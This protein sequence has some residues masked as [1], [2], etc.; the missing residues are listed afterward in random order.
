MQPRLINTFLG[1]ISMVVVL[2]HVEAAAADGPGLHGRVLGLDDEG[3]FVGVVAGATI[4]FKGQGGAVAAQTTS[5]AN[6][7]YRV[8]LPAG[9]YTYKIEA[10]GYR[11]EDEGRG[12]EIH[13]SEGY[14]VHDFSLVRGET[15]KEAQPF[16]PPVVAIGELIGRVIELTEK[17]ER[18]GIPGARISL[19]LEGTTTLR[20]VVSRRS[21]QDREQTGAYAVQLPEGQWR[22]SVSAEGFEPLIDP[23][24]IPIMAGQTTTRDFVLRRITPATPTDQGIKGIVL[25]PPDTARPPI[26]VRIESLLRPGAAIPTLA[27]DAEGRFVQD[28]AVGEYRVLAEAEGFHPAMQMPVS[29]FE[30]RY[31]GVV[32]RL[33][34]L[35]E[36]EKPVEP[37][38]TPQPLRV[39]VT[40]QERTQAGLVPIPKARVLLR[41]DGDALSQAARKDTDAKGGTEFDVEAEGNFVVLAQAAGFKP[42]GTKLHVGQGEPNRA[43]II[44]IRSSAEVQEQLVTV[45]GYVAYKDPTSPTGYRGIPGTR[46]TWR[47]DKQAQAVQITESDTRGAFRVEIP[48]GQYLLELQPPRGFRGDKAEVAVMAEMKPRT[49]VLEAITAPDVEPPVEPLRDVQVAGVVVGTPLLRTGRYVSVPNASITW[50][51]PQVDRSAR[52]D[53]SG[54]FSVALPA[55]LY[56]VR[57]R[58][59]GYDDLAESV[60]VQPGMD[61]VRLVLNRSGEPGPAAMLPLNVRVMQRVAVPRQRIPLATPGGTIPLTNAAITVLQNGRPVAI[62]QSDRDGRYST[63][64]NPGQYDIKVT[65]D[66]FVPGL[67]QVALTTAGVSREI[68]LTPTA[69]PDEQPQGKRTLTLRIVEQTVKPQEVIPSTAPDRVQPRERLKPDSKQ[70]STSGA[71]Q[72]GT[73]GQALSARV[74][75]RTGSALEQLQQRMKRRTDGQGSAGDVSQSVVAPIGG[76]AVVIRLGAQIVASGNADRNGIYRVQLDA[77]A[78]DV[79]VSQQGYVPAQETIRIGASDVTRQIVLTKSATPR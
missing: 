19:R 17:E 22:A 27:P 74:K 38:P 66:G 29:V 24:P 70:P 65:H 71:G 2:A 59:Q 42:G 4:E 49:F 26:R 30:G 14:V 39:A 16:E 53:L 77:G 35:A 55:A 40:V 6:G 3:R 31:T 12:L 68:V 18:V 47:D 46:L 8:D 54:R 15:E 32:L 57:V 5:G 11:T 7:Y 43:E 33:K 23:E 25:L 60:V 48:A 45:T 28:L 51:G 76:A 37:E 36:P 52:S 21:G 78:Y 69:Q 9:V 75:P 73:T 56:Q 72:S 67:A 50:D 44:L 13:H 41:R 63:Q 10:D 20:H 34:P 1:L 58:A 64:L 79:K 62:G 61:A